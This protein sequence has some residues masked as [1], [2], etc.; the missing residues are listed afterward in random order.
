MLGFLATDMYLPAFNQIESSLNIDAESV[1]LSLTL[2]LG[3][4]AVGQLVY[5]GLCERFGK[6]ATLNVGLIIFTLS[7]V[8][9]AMVDNIESFLLLRVVQAFGACAAA[10]IWQSIVIESFD[11]AAAR[12]LFASIMPLV[13]LSPALAPLL[14]SWIVE[15]ASWQHIFAILALL[16]L[17]LAVMTP[18]LTPA[19]K[20]SSTSTENAQSRMKVANI[21]GN[22]TF[23]S[24]VII[25]GA[26]SAAFFCYLTLWPAV[27][28]H[29][30]YDA[31]SIGLSFVPQTIAFMLGGFICRRMLKTMSAQ[32]IKNTLM[33]GF[34]VLSLV[35][36]LLSMMGAGLMAILWVFALLAAINGAIYPL[37]V[38]DAL[39]PFANNAAKAAG[40]Q[41]FI[42]LAMAFAGSYLVALNAAYVEQAIGSGII[43]CALIAL[44]AWVWMNWAQWKHEWCAPDPARI[45]LKVVMCEKTA[46]V[47][48]TCKREAGQST[49]ALLQ[50]KLIKSDAGN[51]DDKA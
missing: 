14:G 24:N 25:F 38:T 39:S 18:Y 7:S 5:G 33:V 46:T 26:C 23:I 31:A 4:L 9:L 42:Q 32:R 41:N 44:S 20:R 47:G 16:G 34:I 12:K 37:L 43:I 51:R 40:W 28:Q 27:M 29:H 11:E 10:V 50:N 30:G 1:A 35:L 8:L 17:C 45:A 2:F 49:E 36:F 6:R 48:D 22:K 15:V 3:G 13:A 21:L 19:A